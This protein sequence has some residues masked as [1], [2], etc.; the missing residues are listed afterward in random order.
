MKFVNLWLGR[1]IRSKSDS[2]PQPFQRMKAIFYSNCSKFT[3]SKTKAE[4]IR[5]SISIGQMVIF[6]QRS[7]EGKSAFSFAGHIS[8]VIPPG[9]GECYRVYFMAFS[10]CRWQSVRPHSEK[11]SISIIQLVA[12]EVCFIFSFLPLISRWQF[13]CICPSTVTCSRLAISV[14]NERRHLLM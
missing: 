3:T 1:N 9:V 6:H 14:P 11:N 10:D 12:G 8:D 5:K 2:S 13:A 4:I 7:V